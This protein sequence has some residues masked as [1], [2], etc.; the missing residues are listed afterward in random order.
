MNTSHG[1]HP[2]SL[3]GLVLPHRAASG[4]VKRAEPLP[5]ANIDWVSIWLAVQPSIAPPSTDAKTEPAPTPTYSGTTESSATS[6]LHSTVKGG[7][8]EGPGHLE[9]SDARRSVV[10]GMESDAATGHMSATRI[11][12]MVTSAAAETGGP[13]PHG[14]SPP[15]LPATEGIRGN[16]RS[17]AFTSSARGV[18]ESIPAAMPGLPLVPTSLGG[19]TSAQTE[20]LIKDADEGMMQEPRTRSVPSVSTT[21][22]AV[23]AHGRHVEV[24]REDQA[25]AGRVTSSSEHRAA[26]AESNSAGI[27]QGSPTAMS[28]T[29]FS[30]SFASSAGPALTSHPPLA[31][32]VHQWDAVVQSLVNGGQR[33]R[34]M[35]QPPELGAC[36]VALQQT[37]DGVRVRIWA[38]QP[39]AR[40]MMQS[41]VGTLV[42][43]LQ[44]VGVRVRDVS[45]AAPAI[46]AV[47]T[48]ALQSSEETNSE[49]TEKSPRAVPIK[50][51]KGLSAVNLSV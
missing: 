50:R 30:S 28:P 49:S 37:S 36:T 29:T 18:D 16:Q 6:V 35:L 43:A 33:V 41:T 42:Q 31:T 20:P 27:M 21:S 2:T 48:T 15:H 14:P 3:S 34:L 51:R 10:W 13:I 25:A 1:A 4:Q 46:H 40:I 19:I 44:S 5:G 47:A 8:R 24:T 23:E 26:A 12:E 9:R 45:V 11:R 39:S 38:E 32:A 17:G 7:V 22:I